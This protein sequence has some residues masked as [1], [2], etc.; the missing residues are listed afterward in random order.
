M[1]HPDYRKPVAA[2]DAFVKSAEGMT[3]AKIDE[4]DAFLERMSS[5]PPLPENML[6]TGAPWGALREEADHVAHL[7]KGCRFN[8]TTSPETQPWI[9]LL[10]TG[11]FS[12][13]TLALTPVSFQ[14]DDDWMARL[15]AAIAAG[16]NTWL[17]YLH[18]GTCHL[19]RGEVI[20]ARAALQ[21][22]YELQPNAH[23]ARNLATAAPDAS[24]ALAYYKQAWAAWEA[25]DLDA[26]P[27][28]ARLGKDL[29]RELTAWLLATKQWGELAAFVAALPD[30]AGLR[31]KDQVM[32]ARAALAVHEGEIHGSL[33][34]SYAEAIDIL[35]SHC[36][37]TYGSDRKLLLNLWLRAQAQRESAELY[38]GRNLTRRE[39]V[40]LKRKMNCDGTSTTSTTPNG[41]PTEQF[42]EVGPPNLRIC[43]RMKA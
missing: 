17:H 5:V 10:R 18:L 9:E 38:G 41:D 31:E 37:P 3:Q 11:T 14:I 25:L 34:G 39:L 42:C 20:P 4:L 24:S 21:K 33:G 27:A 12:A 22:S 16:A 23:A 7:A 32:H 28:A 40:R 8:L 19:E 36:F 15:E 43:I 13:A 30:V 35:S 1:Q 6:T 29:G 26:D 2:V